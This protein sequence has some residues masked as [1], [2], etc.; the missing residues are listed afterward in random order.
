LSR[1][2]APNITPGGEAT[3]IRYSYVAW[4]IIKLDGRILFY[5]RED[6]RKRFDK[7]AGD[8]GLIGGRANQSDLRLV[9]PLV[10]NGD[11]LKALQS[12]DSAIVKSALPEALKR[13]LCEETG[14]LYGTHYTFA[15]WRTLR[16]YRQVQ[17]ATPYHAWTEYYLEI[18]KI[19]LNLDGY[20]HLC[21][22]VKSDER[23]V[24]F[25]IEEIVRGE[26]TDGKV[27]YIKALF[28]DY[29]DNRVKLQED[30]ASIPDSYQC[31][32]LFK[33]EKY[34]MTLTLSHEKL[35][36]AGIL[37]KEKPLDIRFSM[38]QHA[39]LLGLAAHVRG[40]EFVSSPENI[41]F[42][43]CGWVEIA[44]N[45]SMQSSLQSLAAILKDTGIV[46]EN[47]RDTYFR[48]TMC[49]EILF[50][51][52]SL[53]IISFRKSDLADTR[54]KIPALIKGPNLKQL[55][56]KLRSRWKNLN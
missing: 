16:P 43:P 48:L 46:I 49:P 44:E 9:D 5:Q 36:I 29:E 27:A 4:G 47:H 14:L 50:F 53:F 15:S 13:E 24:W 26:S 56:G 17:G 3:P 33:P 37:G 19:D 52:E 25:S 10:D 40:F 30:L 20:F 39:I 23:L 54:S 34:G 21:R 8:Y 51:D 41:R 2:P 45:T 12:A 35:V 32:F 55:L 18:F 31:G 1:T 11:S 6:T 28:S 7:S 22:R 38:E 42:H